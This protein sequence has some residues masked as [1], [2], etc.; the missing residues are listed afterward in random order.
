MNVYMNVCNEWYLYRKKKKIELPAIIYII[1]RYIFYI[2]VKHTQKIEQ[3][4]AA[5]AVKRRKIK[6][7]T[8]RFCACCC[9]Q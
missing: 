5:A 2:V 3:K 7:S 9:W 8:T 4:S 6:F 1:Y